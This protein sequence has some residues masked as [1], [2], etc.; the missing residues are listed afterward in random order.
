MPLK[1]VLQAPIL[2]S[3]AFVWSLSLLWN[4]S[5]FAQ[6]VEASTAATAPVYPLNLTVTAQDEWVVADRKLPGLWSLKAGEKPQVE[7]QGPKRFR[8]RF[9]AIRCVATLPSGQLVVGDTATRGVYLLEGD[10]EP[11]LLS[12]LD[13]GVPIDLA[14]NQQGE[15]FAADLESHRIY[16]MSKTEDSWKCEELIAIAAPRGLF[17]DQDDT[18]WVITQGKKALHKMTAKGE[19]SVVVEE[20][21][22]Q[23]P[24]D[25]AV[26]GETVYVTDGYGK[27]VWTM[28]RDG[29]DRQKLTHETLETPIGLAVAGE[30]LLLVD[31]RANQLYAV[32]KQ[33]GITP[34]GWTRAAK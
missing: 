6:E 11:L 30:K 8:E 9:N 15:I 20:P 31:S 2:M 24:H 23:F 13:V 22:F 5:T 34:L 16:K 27:C 29:S 4:A 32:T 28:G 7:L 1:P 18:L 3:C 10:A 19:W 26:L 21:V 25:V 14:V 17:I 12:G 33:D